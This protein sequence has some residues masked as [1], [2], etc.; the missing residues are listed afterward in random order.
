MNFTILNEENLQYYN[1]KKII[2]YL[3]GIKRI[4]SQMNTRKIVLSNMTNGRHTLK[5]EMHNSEDRLIAGTQSIVVFAYEFLP[6][7][8]TDS[9]PESI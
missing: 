8:S 1:A 3:D 4:E 6:P 2:V 5:M 9:P 7:L